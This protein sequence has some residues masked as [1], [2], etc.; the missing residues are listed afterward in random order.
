[1]LTVTAT[2]LGHHKVR[3]LLVG[4]REA[5]KNEILLNIAFLRLSEADVEKAKQILNADRVPHSA[6]LFAN[7]ATMGGTLADPAQVEQIFQ[8]AG[9]TSIY[10]EY[11]TSAASAILS[12]APM[13]LVNGQEARIEAS[14]TR[15][16]GDF[17]QVLAENGK[18]VLG[19]DKLEPI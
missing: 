8:M 16:Y 13:R 17:M 5:G 10:A 19:A 3:E 15:T 7:D 9:A 4:L 2:P 6:K 12:L 1:V 18:P 14:T 11:D